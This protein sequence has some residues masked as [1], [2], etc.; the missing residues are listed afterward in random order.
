MSLYWLRVQTLKTDWIIMRRSDRQCKRHTRWCEAALQ[1]G[2]FRFHFLVALLFGLSF[3][4]ADEVVFCNGV[5]LDIKDSTPVA[6]AN[7]VSTVRGVSAVADT[8]GRFQLRGAYTSVQRNKFSTIESVQIKFNVSQSGI[9]CFLSSKSDF[10]VRVSILS[11]SGKLLF[12]GIL[13]QSHR[14]LFID[15]RGFGGSSGVKIVSFESDRRKIS[16]P[17][18]FGAGAYGNVAEI[19]YTRGVNRILQKRSVDIGDTLWVSKT[20]YHPIRVPVPLQSGMEH[21]VYLKQLPPIDTS[22]SASVSGLASSID[23]AFDRSVT[24]TSPEQAI[25]SIENQLSQSPDVASVENGSGF[26]VARFVDGSR[27]AWIYRPEGDTLGLFVES[28]QMGK[29][30]SESVSSQK[31]N[32]SACVAMAYGLWQACYNRDRIHLRELGKYHFIKSDE[33][34]PGSLTREFLVKTMPAYDYIFLDGHGFFSDGKVWITTDEIINDEAERNKLAAERP[35]HYCFATVTYR[36]NSQSPYKTIN[37]ILCVSNVF[38]RD[39]LG[40]TALTNSFVFGGSCFFGYGSIMLN[41]LIGRGAQAAAGFELQNSVS[42]ETAYAL[43][44][45]MLDGYATIREARSWIPGNLTSEVCQVNNGW[46]ISQLRLAGQLGFAFRQCSGTKARCDFASGCGLVSSDDSG[47]SFNN[48]NDL[49]PSGSGILFGS[50]CIP[51]EIRIPNR[52]FYIIDYVNPENRQE[53]N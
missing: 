6:F 21:V 44:L 45:A 36:S 14:E 43:S 3:A 49:V 27:K 7:L 34:P 40:A 20:G 47:L 53:V 48:N 1:K 13:R 50:F 25:Q 52:K 11:L 8:L 41:E 35:E 9:H 19:G 31:L 16:F 2:I 22:K 4:Y 37:N 33:F 17:I 15:A 30:L 12:R 5:V 28:G 39:R 26:V 24:A 32:K 29:T 23:S 51:D 38:F 46:A 10:D 42:H 18:V